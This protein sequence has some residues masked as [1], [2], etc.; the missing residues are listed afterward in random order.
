MMSYD[1]NV[2]INGKVP[3][4]DCKHTDFARRGASAADSV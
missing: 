1:S 3:R 2:K 4:Y